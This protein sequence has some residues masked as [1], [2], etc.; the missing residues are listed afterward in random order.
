MALQAQRHA[1]IAGARRLGQTSAA[2][3]GAAANVG[4]KH[5]LRIIQAEGSQRGRERNGRSPSHPA[6]VDVKTSGNGRA[7]DAAARAQRAAQNAA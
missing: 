5:G 7:A 4:S 2:N 6:A 1:F 3:A